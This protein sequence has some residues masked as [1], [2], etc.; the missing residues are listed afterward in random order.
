MISIRPFTSNNRVIEVFFNWRHNFQLVCI[1]V[2]PVRTEYVVPLNISFSQ[3]IRTIGWW[4]VEVYN[5]FTSCIFQCLFV[6]SKTNDQII[7]KKKT[8][9]LSKFVRSII[10]NAPIYLFDFLL[11]ALPCF[12]FFLFAYEDDSGLLLVLVDAVATIWE[13]MNDNNK[14]NKFGITM[15]LIDTIC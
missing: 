1:F 14:L 8:A 12:C 3:S 13:W 10:K 2:Y 11:M 7:K 5:V 6:D 4:F 15:S 9:R